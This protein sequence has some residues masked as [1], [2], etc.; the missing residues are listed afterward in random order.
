[1]IRASIP[2]HIGI[3]SLVVTMYG[4]HLLRADLEVR[5]NLQSVTQ[6]CVMMH[7]VTQ[8]SA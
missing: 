8:M 6:R 1:M 3:A 2:V 4:I 7:D 5:G